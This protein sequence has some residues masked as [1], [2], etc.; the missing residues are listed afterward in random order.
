[1]G[2]ELCSTAKEFDGPAFEV[3][4]KNTAGHGRPKETKQR[5]HT[6]TVRDRFQRSRDRLER[7]APAA[8]KDASA[9]TD[10]FAK[11]DS[12]NCLGPADGPGGRGG[13]TVVHA[14][15]PEMVYSTRTRGAALTFGA[16]KC[17]SQSYFEAPKL[18]AG[19][20]EARSKLQANRELQSQPLLANALAAVAAFSA[21]AAAEKAA[22]EAK[23]AAEAKAA[24]E[25]KKAVLKNLNES[26]DGTNDRYKRV[27][28]AAI[29]AVEEA[30]SL[31]AAS[32]QALKD[33]KVCAEKP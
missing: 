3:V 29:K 33:I 9:I 10:A 4:L 21:A 18:L 11:V 5:Q 8:Q 28:D 30:R 24:E 13:A 14:A 27:F 32:A 20:Q 17:D 16:S 15:P 7:N 1:M 6:E 19:D 2:N 25:A 31:G 22:K 23:A 26:L 12:E